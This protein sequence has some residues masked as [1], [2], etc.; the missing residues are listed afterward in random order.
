MAATSLEKGFQ[1]IAHP[2]H[3]CEPSPTACQRM[4][5][6]RVLFLLTA[7]VPLTLLWY[8]IPA[9]RH[10]S[11]KLDGWQYQKPCHHSAAFGKA[12][13]ALWSATKDGYAGDGAVQRRL[14]QAF[15]SVPSPESAREAL[16][17]YTT[18]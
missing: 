9:Y 7:I 2:E 18:Q 10:Y 15:L 3:T 8:N 14:E 16:Y 6:S 13:A 1:A 12:D 5:R 11:D 17:N 4:R